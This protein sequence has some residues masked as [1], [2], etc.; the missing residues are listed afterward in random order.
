M[1][2]HS[3][4]VSLLNVLLSALIFN[5]LLWLDSSSSSVLCYFIFIVGQNFLLIKARMR[6]L[7]ADLPVVSKCGL[8]INKLEK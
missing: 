4:V 2:D 1:C 3:P 6:N 5:F 8:I 7:I